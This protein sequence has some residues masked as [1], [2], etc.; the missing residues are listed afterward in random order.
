MNNE[1]MIVNIRPFI[2]YLIESEF[3][4]SNEYLMFIQTGVETRSGRNTNAYLNL[5]NYKIT[6]Q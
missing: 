6:T 3:L 2:D 1:K 4:N 5:T